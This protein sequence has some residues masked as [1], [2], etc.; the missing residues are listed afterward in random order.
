MRIRG[1]FLVAPLG[2][3]LCWGALAQIGG[4]EGDVKGVD[5]KPILNAIVK[6][7]REDANRAYQSKTDKKGHY[8]YSG[9]PFGYYT[10]LVQVDGKEG[11]RRERRSGAEKRYPVSVDFDL[12]MTPQEL[13]NRIKLEFKRG[14]VGMVDDPNR[15]D[16]G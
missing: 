12:R 3:L 16:P 10:I 4:F 15:A 2:L 7:S 14:R 5:G 9:L 11:R 8:F 1:Q 6:I 13:E